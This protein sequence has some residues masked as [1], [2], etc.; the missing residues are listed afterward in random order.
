MPL[1]FSEFKHARIGFG[2]PVHY[3]WTNGHALCGAGANSKGTRMPG[4]AHIVAAA[5]NCIKCQVAEAR[6]N[7]TAK[8]APRKATFR[9][10]L[11]DGKVATRTSTHAYTHVVAIREIKPHLT[12]WWC[13][14]RSDA[15][16]AT[17]RA[18]YWL[19]CPATKQGA[20]FETR[21]LTVEEVKK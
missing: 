9:V 18:S 17:K 21:V 11:P 20:R 2:G 8:P 16:A 15:V 14:W 10:T 12:G 5:V 6:N 7:G 3:I 4:R 19:R 13:E 1:N